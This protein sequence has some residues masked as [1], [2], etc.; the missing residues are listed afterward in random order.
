MYDAIIIGTGQSG[1]SLAGRFSKEGKRVA[2]IERK[3]FGGTCVNN[4]CTPTKAL[5]ANAKAMHTVR[6]A[7][8][9]GIEVERFT[10]DM[11]KVKARKDALVKESARG[12][13]EWLKGM[14]GCT[15]IE[16]Q[17]VFDGPNQVRVNNQVIEGEKIFINVGGRA[18]RP[19]IPGLEK[20]PYL[21]NSS[22]MDVDYLPE[23][24]LIVGGG[25]IAVEFAQ[26]FRRFGSKVTLFQRRP[27]IMP[28]EDVDVSLAI[29]EI[30][31]KEGIEIITEAK[32]LEILPESK[33][34]DIHIKV[35]QKSF[36]GTHLLLA[37]GRIPNTDDLGLEKAGIEVDKRGF[38]KVDDTLRTSRPHIWAIGDCNG[39]GAFTHTSYNDYEIV[40][41]N[42]FDN[43]SRKASDRIPI[44]ALFI[45]PPLGRVGMTEEQVKESGI[46]ALKATLPMTKVAR[47][48]EKGETEGFMK[49]LVDAESKWILG[50]SFL[51]TGCDEV[52]QMIAN[53]I[54]AKAPYTSIQ[55]C[56]H[57]HPTVTE[58]VPSL[59][60]G[61]KPIAA[62]SLTR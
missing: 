55:Q 57:I 33:E 7:A 12:V 52:I 40:A 4:G 14:G 34:G 1:P 10:I 42:L 9:F 39:R 38:I 48:R 50:A 37:T 47:A 36:H 15:V 31:K 2:I 35:E 53:I 62:A 25:Y 61:L 32:E 29:R 11:K 30:L 44:Y 27:H 6:N 20:V 18:D 26:I 58:L 21:N 43:A 28:K 41:A 23:H 8:F 17:A 56:V 60:E 51:G 45:D 19:R 16:G 49:I 3:R 54:Q 24:L 59:L 13:H 5:V 22:L 46:S